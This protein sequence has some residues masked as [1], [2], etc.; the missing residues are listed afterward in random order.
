MVVGN[1]AMEIKGKSESHCNKI[2]KTTNG[3]W[4]ARSP[5]LTEMEERLMGV[6]GWRTVTGDGNV[7]LGLVSINLTCEK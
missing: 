1:R 5:P 7:E 6:L 3:R 4:E 2:R